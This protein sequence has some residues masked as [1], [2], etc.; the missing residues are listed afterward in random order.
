MLGHQ[1]TLISGGPQVDYFWDLFDQED[2]FFDKNGGI[3]DILVR[4]EGEY[5]LPLLL[6]SKKEDWLKIPNLVY[7]SDGNVISTETSR[8]RD[9][10]ALPFPN[11]DSDVYPAMEDGKIKFINMEGHYSNYKANFD[12]NHLK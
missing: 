5:A 10:D 8:V 9:L 7:K 4:N 6:G 2:L 12:K 3:F 1:I 11:F